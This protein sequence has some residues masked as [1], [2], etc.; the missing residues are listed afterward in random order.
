VVAT[1]IDD[2]TGKPADIGSIDWHPRRP[3]P[4]MGGACHPVE[5]D[6]E[7]GRFAFRA[8]RGE[9]VLDVMESGYRSHSRRVTVGAG[10]TEVTLR[11]H[12]TGGGVHVSV[13]EGD[14]VFPWKDDWK[15]KLEPLE[16]SGE[17]CSRSFSVEGTILEMS[18]E[19]L[20][21]L[22]FPKVPGFEPVPPR[23]VRVSRGKTTEVVIRLTRAR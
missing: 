20:Y 16:G 4:G 21:R 19:G 8:P 14:A 6:P 22:T 15:V 23:D 13:M 7:T 3:E 10:T 1:V 12:P 9:I 2:T 18:E 11:I 5:R 17:V